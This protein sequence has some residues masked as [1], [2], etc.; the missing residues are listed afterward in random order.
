ME[1]K[2]EVKDVIKDPLPLPKAELYWE[3][4]DVSKE[5]IL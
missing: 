2:R 4:I 3:D 1:G 5:G